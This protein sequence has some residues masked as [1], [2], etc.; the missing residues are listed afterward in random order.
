MEHDRLFMEAALVEGTADRKKREVELD[1]IAEGF[2]NKRDGHY[3]SREIL[4][5]H[6]KDFEGA[7]Q[8]VDHLDPETL[9]KLNGMPRSV[10]DLAGR[11]VETWVDTNSEGKRVIRGRAKVAQPWLWELIENDPDLLGVSI[12]AWGKS[13][14]GQ[15]NGQ[16]ARIV[17]GISKIGSVDWVT[18]AGAGGK[19]VSLVEAQ[20]EQEEQEMATISELSVEQLREERPDL[21]DELLDTLISESD[22]EKPEAEE[23]QAATA[24]ATA[25]PEEESEEP[26]AEESEE[27]EAEGEEPEESEDEEHEP[28]DLSDEEVAEIEAAIED[29]AT[30]LAQS[31]LDEAVDAAV[32]VMRKKFEDA[33]LEQ[34][35]EFERQL[36]IRDQRVIAA[37]MIEQA[38][39][40]RA[41]EQALKEEFHDAYFPPEENDNGEEIKPAE[42]VLKEAVEAAI[43]RKRSELEEYT[44]ARV[45]G[46]GESGTSL[47]EVE[48]P[49]P[50]SAPAD[51]KVDSLLGI[52][53]AP[54]ENGSK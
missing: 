44:E 25:E 3:Y 51:Q 30:E 49:S 11:L 54:S 19:V 41:T 34:Q 28:I 37:R 13:K 38:G 23:S 22:E 40:K 18:E 8:Y 48:K 5:R 1:L 52:E 6:A 9:K 35:D 15:V 29:R 24:T 12:N 17:E 42:D 36:A 27:E 7:K 26:T 10:R 31:K 4:E 32:E 50:K 21:V 2:G 16:Q 39:F 45:S 53:E 47:R 46:A 43:E 33:L 20:L 14:D